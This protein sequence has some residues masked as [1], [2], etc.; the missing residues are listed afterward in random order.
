SLFDTLESLREEDLSRIIYIRNEGMTVEDA[1]IRQLCHYS[2][3]VG[4][5][6]YK[7][8]QL[9][10]GNWKTLSIARN[11]S[12]AYNFKK[13]EQIKEEKHFL[14]SLLDESR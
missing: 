2:Y 3:H 10:N 4:Q 13:F 7:G 12:T 14:D 9:S 8:K 6:V 5:I 1:I 11:D